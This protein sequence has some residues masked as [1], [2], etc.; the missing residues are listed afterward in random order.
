MLT[1]GSSLGFWQANRALLI[2]PSLSQCSM[3]YFS[4][5]SMA[6]FQKT[7]ILSVIYD[8]KSKY[9]LPEMVVC[10]DYTSPCRE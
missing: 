1:F 2:A 6:L 10:N 8:S 5:A 4:A 3:I 7:I 9:L